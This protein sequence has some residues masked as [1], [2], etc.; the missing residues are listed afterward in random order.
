MNQWKDLQ[1]E[2]REK[3]PALL[4]DK[5]PTDS[6]KYIPLMQQELD[7]LQQIRQDFLTNHFEDKK[8]K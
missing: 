2:V 3:L 5:I 1:D 6:S 7:H 8:T 4:H